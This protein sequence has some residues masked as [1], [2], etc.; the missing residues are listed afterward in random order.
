MHI[1][2]E[3]SD[4]LLETVES[5]LQCIDRLSIMNLIV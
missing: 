2:N 4:L 1:R 3:I 5:I